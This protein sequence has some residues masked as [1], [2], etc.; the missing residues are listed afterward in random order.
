[1]LFASLPN[2][3]N[4]VVVS[5]QGD[6]VGGGSFSGDVSV[7]V[8]KFSWLAAGSMAS[9]SPNPMNPEGTLT[10]VTTQPGP[11]SVHLFDVNG[12]LVRTV[13]ASQYVMPGVHAVT[14]DGRGEQG[15]RLASGV[16]FYRV[17]GP[18][19][20]IQGSFSVLR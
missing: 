6:L 11:T 5:V 3:A 14:I 8:I 17:L 7:N 13:M 15:S 19:G 1:M 2:G 16:Y 18:D 20:P 10:F 12:R 9:I 4:T